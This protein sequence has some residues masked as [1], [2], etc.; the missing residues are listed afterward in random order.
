MLSPDWRDVADGVLARL[1]ISAGVSRAYIT[2]NVVIDG[3]DC[4]DQLAEW[5]APG[6]SSQF[7]DPSMTGGPWKDHGFDRWVKLL[8]LGELI[9]SRVQDLPFRERDE[10]QS[11]DILSIA[12]F[13]VTVE[14]E[15]WGLIGFELR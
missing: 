15:W 9:Q 3:R 13:P 2:R 5:C 11:Q 6:I 1:G 4:I 10:L 7:S 8:R 12:V 14:G